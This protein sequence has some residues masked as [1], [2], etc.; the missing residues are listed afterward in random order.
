MSLIKQA[1]HELKLINFGDEDTAVMLYIMHKFFEQWDSGGAV[2]AVAPIL[3]RLIA[4]KPL[5]PLTGADDEWFEHDNGVFQNIRCSSVFK[6]PRFHEGKL[7]YNIDAAEPRAAIT[8][9]YWPERAD[10]L[11]PVMEVYHHDTK[12]ETK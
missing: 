8:F 3:Q 12:T 7:A 6:D 2:H 4:G 5:S 11:S 1:E 9:P 10:V